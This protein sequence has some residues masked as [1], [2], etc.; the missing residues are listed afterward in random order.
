MKVLVVANYNRGKFSP[1]IT[2]QVQQ[3]ESL[4]CTVEYLG[5]VGKGI[6]GYLK[7]RK[8]LINKITE[9]QPQIIHAHYGFSGFLANLQRRVPVI[10]TYHGSDINNTVPRLISKI[11]IALSKHNIF[12]S[13]KLAKKAR[14]NKK[15]SIIS[16][17]VNMSVFHVI[18]KN[19]ARNLMGLVNKYYVLFSSAFT[20][21]NKNYKLAKESIEVLINKS[22]DVELIELKNYSP[23]EVNLLMNASDCVIVTSFKESGPLVIK[24]AMAVNTPAVSVNVGDVEEVIGQCQGYFICDYSPEDISNKLEIVLKHNNKTMGRDRIYNLE[25]DSES[26]GKKI[27]SIYMS[28]LN[29]N[30]S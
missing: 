25:L 28:I 22:Y 7:N 4:G 16:C 29:K 2:A 3:L 12:V 21:A 5:I 10:T 20:Q 8:S 26:V 11:S 14:V 19:E 24:E 1:F 30:N 27:I 13:N 15:Y 6:F 18:D 9:Y 17:G 23:E